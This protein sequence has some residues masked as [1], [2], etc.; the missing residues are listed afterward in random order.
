MYATSTQLKNWT[1]SSSEELE[2]MR[3]EANKKYSE[4]ISKK[5]SMQGVELLTVQEENLVRLYYES[6]LKRLC[7][8]FQ[9]PIPR[10][11]FV[12]TFLHNIYHYFFK[13]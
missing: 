5:N 10:N 12:R 11:V 4:K 13:Y 1:F 9:P 2:K 6:K 3:Y 8:R 7:G